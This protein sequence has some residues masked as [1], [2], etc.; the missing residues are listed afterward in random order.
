PTLFPYPTLFRSVADLLLDHPGAALHGERA[1]AADRRRQQLGEQRLGGARLAD[2]HQPALA[3]QG[4]DGALDQR[5]VAV[6]LAG[7]TPPADAVAPAAEDE[8]T[9][10]A[11]A[12]APAFGA[13]A[14]IALQQRGQFLGVGQF[15]GQPLGRFRSGSGGL[16]TTWGHQSLSLLGT[17]LAAIALN[18]SW[19]AACS[20]RG[21]SCGLSFHQRPSSP[22]LLVS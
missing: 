18:W 6:D 12:E 1:V 8:G 11:R 2:Q 21:H 7:D 14:V 17:A 22:R 3:G 9:H 13:R 10:R 5:V 19:T 4:D 15:G 20:E 16:A